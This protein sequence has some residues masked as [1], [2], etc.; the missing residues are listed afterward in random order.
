[1]KE[2]KIELKGGKSVII[3]EFK[4]EDFEGLVETYQDMSDDAL[5]LQR[6]RDSYDRNNL[7]KLCREENLVLIAD[8]ENRIV[9]HC[10][11]DVKHRSTKKGIAYL[12]INILQDFQ[13]KGL[14][15]E[16]LDEIIGLAEKDD[17]HRIE[18]E[19]VAENKA[20]IHLHEKMR[21]EEEGRKRD[22]FFGDNG[23]YH[24]KLVFGLLPLEDC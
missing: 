4:D 20:S 18:S 19:V 16:M 11:L 10:M 7:R 21:F 15:T 24:D 14:G 12:I 17:L 9:G 2:R 1:M 3:S 22:S 13:G 5:R 23:E 6:S 8:F